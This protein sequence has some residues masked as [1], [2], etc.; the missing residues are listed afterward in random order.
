VHER[1]F[2]WRDSAAHN[3]LNAYWPRAARAGLLPDDIDARRSLL[4]LFLLQKAFY[5]IG[6]EAANRPSW[7]S[8]PVRGVL[9]LLSPGRTWGDR[10]A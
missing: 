5:E 3:F 9:D 10:S 7:I 6:Y 1:A 8:I 4:E 2:A